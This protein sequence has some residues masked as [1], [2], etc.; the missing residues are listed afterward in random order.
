MTMHLSSTSVYMLFQNI[1][2][3]DLVEVNVGNNDYVLFDYEL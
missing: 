2:E 1:V 3:H